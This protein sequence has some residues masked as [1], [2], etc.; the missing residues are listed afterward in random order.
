MKKARGFSRYP[1]SHRRRVAEAK[2]IDSLDEEQKWLATSA[3]EV[4]S[5]ATQITK[6]MGV[7]KAAMSCGIKKSEL[8]DAMLNN[9]G[10][11]RN[12]R[13]II[14]ST[15]LGPEGSLYILGPGHRKPT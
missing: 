2:F 3:V 6:T 12:D 10:K 7:Q 4:H 13:F 11:Y 8:I 9:E 1:G 15:T 14:R 5:L